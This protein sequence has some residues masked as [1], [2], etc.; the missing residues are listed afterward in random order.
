MHANFLRDTVPGLEQPSLAA[1]GAAERAAVQSQVQ[2]EGGK[3][4]KDIW[5]AGQGVA[6]AKQVKPIGEIVEDLVREYVD[7]VR[8]LPGL[9]P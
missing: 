4:W 9:D 3:K 5:S 8:A 2:K 7:A 6:L 1:A